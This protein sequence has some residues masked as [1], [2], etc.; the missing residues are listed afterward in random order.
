MSG[1]ESRRLR[2]ELFRHGNLFATGIHLAGKSMVF[3]WWPWANLRNGFICIAE[4]FDR[5][6]RIE[7]LNWV[8]RNLVTPNPV[9]L[10]PDSL[11][12]LAGCLLG[13]FTHGHHI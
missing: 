13:R 3:V 6:P 11:V 2:T 12:Q 4:Q 7:H 9:P 5:Y 10:S 1:G 8:E